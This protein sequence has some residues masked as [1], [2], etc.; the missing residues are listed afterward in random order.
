MCTSLISRLQLYLKLN[1]MAMDPL[2]IRK[3]RKMERADKVLSVEELR[4]QEKHWMEMWKAAKA[5]LKAAREELRGEADE[6]V[7]AE[8]MADIEGLKKRKCDWGQLLGLNEASADS[9]MTF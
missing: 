6:E 3:K 4:V 2:S 8:L 1:P 9:T 5:E 7:R